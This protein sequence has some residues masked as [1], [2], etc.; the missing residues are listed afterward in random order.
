[1]EVV[2]E[3]MRLKPECVEEYLAMHRDT[4]P[5]LV[6]AIRNS[7]FLEEYIYTIGCVVIVIM[8]CESFKASVE[9][10]LATEVYRRWTTRVRGMLVSDRRLFGTDE[11]LVDLFP[12]WS[13]SDLD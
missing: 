7:G 12:I 8:K 13:L 6:A 3:L 11:I 9:R 5:E 4:W 10:L 1:M 2:C